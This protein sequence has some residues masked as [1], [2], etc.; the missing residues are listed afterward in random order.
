MRKKGILLFLFIF[1]ISLTAFAKENVELTTK[2]QEYKTQ[3]ATIYHEEYIERYKKQDISKQ[4]KQTVR[5]DIVLGNG[6]EVKLSYIAE[7]MGNFQLANNL[8]WGEKYNYFMAGMVTSIVTSFISDI[9][10]ISFIMGYVGSYS[11]LNYDTHDPVDYDPL[12]KN[13]SVLAS[14]IVM[15]SIGGLAKAGIGVLAYFLY[16]ASSYRFNMIQALSLVNSYNSQLKSKL[17]LPENLDFDI[18]FL[19]SDNISEFAFSIKF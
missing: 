12:F 5:Y 18:N 8:K 17:G 19:T 15:F 6:E 10:G 13:D 11:N 2:I 1:T 14:S 7:Q 9:I 16:K 4:Y 3:E